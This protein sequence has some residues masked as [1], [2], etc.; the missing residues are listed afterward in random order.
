MHRTLIAVLLTILVWP[1]APTHAARSETFS[2]YIQSV[3]RNR[4]RVRVR[5]PQGNR[6]VVWMQVEN[7]WRGGQLVGRKILRPGM[8]VMVTAQ[9]YKREWRA[10][11]FQ[12]L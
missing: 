6:R 10:T 5:M 4:Y 8:R 7:V 3:D 1:F 12:V 9:R 11:R 2:G